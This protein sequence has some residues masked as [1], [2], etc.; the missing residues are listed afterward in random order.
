MFEL[1]AVDP[2]SLVSNLLVHKKMSA[3]TIVGVSI[4]FSLI[5]YTP[6]LIV[7]NTGQRYCGYHIGLIWTFRSEYECMIKYEY[8]FQIS[9]KV[10][11][12]TLPVISSRKVGRALQNVI[13]VTSDYLHHA[14][15]VDLKSRTST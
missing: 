11:S 3:K 9:K 6:F 15:S 4:L 5:F 12:L 13:R 1:S 10:T 14:N 2:R 8:D 7:I